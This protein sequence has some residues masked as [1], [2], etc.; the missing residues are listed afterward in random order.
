MDCKTNEVDACITRLLEHIQAMEALLHKGAKLAPESPSFH[1]T[2]RVGVK[3]AAVD[4]V[5]STNHTVCLPQDTTSAHARMAV[6]ALVPAYTAHLVAIQ[7]GLSELAT[8]FIGTP[9][10]T[11]KFSMG[12]EITEREAIGWFHP[13]H[14]DPLTNA[15]PGT[16]HDVHNGAFGDALRA[17][18]AAAGWRVGPMW[19]IHFN[20][21]PYI[22]AK[23]AT[24]EDALLQVWALHKPHLFDT[25]KGLQNSVSHIS[26][27]MPKTSDVVGRVRASLPHRNPTT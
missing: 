21:N 16:G 17:V 9:G 25:E 24:Q 15:C 27:V 12:V 19:E 7:N 4:K 18:A 3:V 22:H 23:A 6:E 8:A 14:A 10:L 5:L 13:K 1:F 11:S 26:Q 20:L 2:C